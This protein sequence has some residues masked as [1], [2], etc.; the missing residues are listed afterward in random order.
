MKSVALSSGVFETLRSALLRADGQEDLRFVSWRQSRGSERAT[1]I[2][3]NV[4]E[5]RQGDRNLHGNVSFEPS[6][7]ERALGSAVDGDVGLAFIHTHPRGRGWQGMSGDDRA[8]EAGMA[9]AVAAATGRPLVGLTMAGDGSI[10]A[11]WW[12]RRAPRRYEPATCESVRV[13][14]DRLLVTYDEA[15][16][17]A[18]TAARTQARSVSAWGP[19]TQALIARLRVGVVGL[20]SVGSIVAE[21]LARTGVQHIRLIDFDSVREENLDRLLH[22]RPADARSRRAKVAVIADA[23]ANS[24][25]AY[26][27]H[28]DGLEFSVVEEEGFRAALDCDLLFSCVD[29]PWARAVLNFAA[30]AHLIPVIDGGVHV[31]TRGGRAMVDADWRAHVA[32]PGRRCLACIG[33]YDPGL[34]SVEREG[35][36]QRS[37]Y[38]EG[39]PED[40]PLRANQNVFAFSVGAASL[41]L[42][43]FVAM[44]AAP[45]GT[46]DLGAL[47]FHLT[48]AELTRDEAGCDPGCPYSS[49]A[50][51]GL[52]DATEMIVTGSHGAAADERAYRAAG[53]RSVRDRL[54]RVIRRVR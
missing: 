16:R 45:S 40:H 21:G 19:V 7:F 17:P 23:L 32:A 38:I 54:Q 20:G 12:E 39:L 30:Y 49:R 50:L 43:Q 1:A 48:G 36:L 2:V 44:V 24:C 42:A 15:L 29:R 52:G 28:V 25:T 33:Q 47:H 22:A 11:R 27:P 6:Y 3:S 13:V 51:Q 53:H 4:I 46:A 8:A 34:V 26:R 18:P 31:R 41:Q 9:A 14:G 35:F 5:P 37:G 10:S